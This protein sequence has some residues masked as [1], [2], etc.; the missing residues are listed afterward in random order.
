MG[1]I[2]ESE[3]AQHWL[4]LALQLAQRAADEEE[5]PVGAVVVYQ[6]EVIGE[7]WNQPIARCD[8]SAHAEILALRQAAARLNNYRLLDATLYVTL[9]PCA[10]CLGA[11]L[12]ARI[13]NLIFGAWDPKAGAVKSVFQILDAPQL[14]HR[15]S[16]QGG[17]LADECAALLKTFFHQRRLKV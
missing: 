11:M 14:N 6:N 13:K 4:H 1:I 7:G 5:V 12:Q 3:T 17:L 15:I 10:M 16:W 9:E 2:H 8:P